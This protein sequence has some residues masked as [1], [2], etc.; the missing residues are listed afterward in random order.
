MIWPDADSPGVNHWRSLGPPAAAAN[1]DL[2]DYATAQVFFEIV[3]RMG[4]N[5]TWANFIKTAEQMKNYKTGI[6]PPVTFGKYS[7]SQPGSRAGTTGALIAVF[8]N[9]NWK[10]TSDFIVPKN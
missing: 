10:Q 3:R 1:F 8:D 2:Q 7:E 6:I 9:G 4:N 5:L